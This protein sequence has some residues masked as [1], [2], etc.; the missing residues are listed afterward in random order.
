LVHSKEEDCVNLLV[1]YEEE[2][3]VVCDKLGV[4]QWSGRSE[5][6]KCCCCGGYASLLGYLNESLVLGRLQ[7]N[8]I[9]LSHQSD[10]T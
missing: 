10:H 3:G 7:S 6:K 1:I 5:P 2:E 4:D 8:L 9:N